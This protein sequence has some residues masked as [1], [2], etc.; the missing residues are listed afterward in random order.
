MG[1]TSKDIAKIC[2]VS[3]GT[4]D[5]ALNN[6]PRIK[7]ETKERILKT[8]KELGYRPDLLARSLVKG[9][10]MSLG[11]VVFD[12]RN[13]YFAQLLNSIE[14]T[15][16]KKGYFVN[17]TLQEK[18]PEMEIKLIN[19]LVDRRVDGIIL[20][21]VNK[22]ETF[23]KFLQGLPI[24]V[25]VVGNQIA[26][27]IPFIGIDEYKAAGDALEMILSKGYKRI[28][29][30]C[31]PLADKEKENIYSHE[32]RLAGFL[33]TARKTNN[34]EHIVIDHWHYP[35]EIKK[36]VNKDNK[37]TAFFCSGDTF[38]LETMKLLKGIG[39]KIPADVGIMGF[40]Y[41]DTLKY[42]TPAL[43]TIYNPVEEIGVKAVENLTNL[44]EGKQINRRLLVKHKIVAG[45]SI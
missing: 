33:D 40:D 30:V 1:I 7:P 13:R 22:G 16:K 31:P 10:T 29:F 25:M 39:K 11:V 15:A 37:K 6:K 23:Q 5:R 27:G 41:I 4:V 14:I 44:I 38:A 20:C 2:G 3:R 43:T 18:D 28:I 8:A 36:W 45:A 32:K 24:P 17:I 26:P 12:V 42:V 34:I 35:S 21:P 9:K 19:S